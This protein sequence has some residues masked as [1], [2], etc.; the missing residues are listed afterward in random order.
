[1]RACVHVARRSDFPI[2]VPP[3]TPKAYFQQAC[4]AMCEAKR[5]YDVAHPGLDRFAETRYLER[6]YFAK[7]AEEILMCV[8][9]FITKVPTTPH[10]ISLPGSSW[11]SLGL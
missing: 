10:S 8:S 2:W 7:I 4:Q 9:D 6:P 1:M 5:V 11:S 3:A